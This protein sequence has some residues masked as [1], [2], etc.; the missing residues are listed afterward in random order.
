MQRTARR[1]NVSVLCRCGPFPPALGLLEHEDS[2]RNLVNAMVDGTYP[3]EDGLAAFEAAK[4]KGALK[5][6]I[7]MTQ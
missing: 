5:I 2:M 7:V 1:H 4:S 3:L 6:Q